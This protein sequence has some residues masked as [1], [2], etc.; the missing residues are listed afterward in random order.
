MYQIL[1]G[2]DGTGD[3]DDGVYANNFAASNV[4]KLCGNA[5]SF[6]ISG[7]LRGP[8]WHGS[9]TQGKANAITGWIEQQIKAHQKLN[10]GGT[11]VQ[12]AQPKVFLTGYSRGGAAVI[13][14][15]H[16]LKRKGVEVHCMLLFDAVDR[17]TMGDTDEI[18]NNVNWV[19]HAM[20]DPR[21]GS[22]ESF[23]NCG[24]KAAPGVTYYSKQFFC[25]HGGMGG[26][27]WDKAGDSGK[28]E[29]M[30]TGAKTGVVAAGT[31]GGGIIGGYKA[32]QLA[33]KHDFTNVTLA[34]EKR[35]TAE[36]WGWMQGNLSNIRHYGMSP[37]IQPIKSFGKTFQR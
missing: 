30:S 32:K 11:G 5:G 37:S 8:A 15:A 31:L 23:G 1:G 33:D 18:P 13:N 12:I 24:T 3:S 25:T 28:I 35:G 17:S 27:P 7:Y 19:F 10:A 2:I 20:R 34:Q 14:A 29:E 16:Q 36:V 21:A 22:R 26:T 6:S 4:T 9:S